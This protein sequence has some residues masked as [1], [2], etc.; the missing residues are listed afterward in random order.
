MRAAL[1]P[2]L[3]VLITITLF[4]SSAMIEYALPSSCGGGF[5]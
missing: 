5:S 4:Y 2:I 1:V 3:M